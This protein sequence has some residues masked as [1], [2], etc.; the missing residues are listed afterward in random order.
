MLTLEVAPALILRH[1]ADPQHPSLAQ[2]KPLKHGVRHGKPLAKLDKRETCE[3]WLSQIAQ[4]PV[5]D[6]A[7]RVMKP[8]TGML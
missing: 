5:E 8:R 4:A 7:W 3:G 2:F 1:S 6:M